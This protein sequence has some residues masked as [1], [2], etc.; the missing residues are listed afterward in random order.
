VQDLGRRKENYAKRFTGE[1]Y[2]RAWKERGGH[3]VV[4]MAAEVGT[5]RNMPMPFEERPASKS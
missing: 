4:E 2:L 5:N 1:D 3:D